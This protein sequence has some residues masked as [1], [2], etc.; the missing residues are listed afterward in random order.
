MHFIFKQMQ[1]LLEYDFFFYIIFGGF[2]SF[3]PTENGAAGK[4]SNDGAIVLFSI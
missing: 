1:K 2:S 3:G 4:C